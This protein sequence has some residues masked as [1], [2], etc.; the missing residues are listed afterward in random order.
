MPLMLEADSDKPIRILIIVAHPDDI[1]FGA[2]GSVARW[3]DKGAT[4]TYCIVT[5]GAAGSNDPTVT[6][7]D[8]IARRQTEQRAAAQI[9]GV[10]DVRFLGYADGALES[11]L[12]LRRDLT[13]IIR[14]VRP[15]RVVLMDPTTMLVST[16]EF[17]YINHPDHRAAGEAALYAVFPSAETRPIFP[18][19]LDEKLEPH[20]VTELYL[21]LSDKPNLAVDVSA[22]GDR[23]IESLLQHRS[24]IG[25]EV[26]EMVRGW[27]AR[28]AA[29]VAIDG[30]S[31]AE[32]FRVLR[33]PV[34]VPA[35]IAPDPSEATN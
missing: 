2:G 9:V 35:P 5:D 23:K 31:H 17:D 10:Y 12:A 24:Q 33:F 13:R 20:H 1:E 3:V 15:D 29:E 19:L 4:V 25:E 22:Y 28:G 7:D 6:R 18:E 8:L 27:D 30:V 14:Q 21:V 34:N 11:T 32:T 26:V 16:G